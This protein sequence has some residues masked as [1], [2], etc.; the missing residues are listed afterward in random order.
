MGVEVQTSCVEF[1]V[2]RPRLAELCSA[3]TSPVASRGT[4]LAGVDGSDGPETQ[5]PILSQD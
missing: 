5:Q 1:S 3:M 4:R 2:W